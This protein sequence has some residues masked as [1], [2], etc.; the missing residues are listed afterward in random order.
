MDKINENQMRGIREE[1]LF[2]KRDHSVIYNSNLDIIKTYPSINYQRVSRN[3]YEF[4]T[5]LRKQHTDGN[6]YLCI[7]RRRTL[8]T[9]VE[10]DIRYHNLKALA[11]ALENFHKLVYSFSILGIVCPEIDTYRNEPAFPKDINQDSEEIR[12][13]KLTYS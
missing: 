3:Q 12:L 6:W 1:E 11:L 9:Y 10:S 7:L 8:I 2:F 5:F 13:R 4:E